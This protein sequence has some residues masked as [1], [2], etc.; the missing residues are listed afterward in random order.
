MQ[1]RSVS[2]ATLLERAVLILDAETM[3]AEG[4]PHHE[5][6]CLAVDAAMSELDIP[7]SRQIPMN[8]FLHG[9]GCPIASFNAF[10]EFRTGEERQTARAIWLTF[11]AEVARD[12]NLRLRY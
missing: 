2:F 5:F 9:L 6:S 12:R 4:R 1:V 11:A 7:W 10:D 8:I 3:K